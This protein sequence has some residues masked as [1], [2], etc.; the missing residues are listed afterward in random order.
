MAVLVQRIARATRNQTPLRKITNQS[1]Y[2]I[3]RCGGDVMWFIVPRFCSTGLVKQ[4]EVYTRPRASNSNIAIQKS[5]EYA[6]TRSLRK[7]S[8]GWWFKSEHGF[9]QLD[10]IVDQFT[11]KALIDFSAPFIFGEITLVM[12]LG[13]N[14]DS[15][16][17][18]AVDRM[19]GAPEKP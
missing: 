4:H 12:A 2:P 5:E 11:K 3:V 13:K 17:I 15:H 6:A 1:D 16:R 18:Q 10:R 7:Q 9:L 19:G 14:S 8:F